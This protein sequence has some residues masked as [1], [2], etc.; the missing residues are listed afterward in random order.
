[1]PHDIP[2]AVA[3]FAALGWEHSHDVVDMIADLES[4]R[5]PDLARERQAQPQISLARAACARL[6]GHGI[7]TALVVQASHLLSQAGTHACRI[8]WTTRA[9]FYGRCGYQPW[10]R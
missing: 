6:H 3:F 10:R 7:G 4:Y 8:G 9:P 5:T 2:G 1:V